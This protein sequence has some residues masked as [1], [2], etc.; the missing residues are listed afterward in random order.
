MLPDMTELE[1]VPEEDE[2]ILLA[3]LEDDFQMLMDENDPSMF[4]W[5]SPEIQSQ[6]QL[7]YSQQLLTE[8]LGMEH[9]DCSKCWCPVDDDMSDWMLP[10]TCECSDDWCMCCG[11]NQGCQLGMCDE[12]NFWLHEMY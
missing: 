5:G 6:L 3:M 8:T 1:E 12:C 2:A 4:V 9:H 11:E 10:N 7:D